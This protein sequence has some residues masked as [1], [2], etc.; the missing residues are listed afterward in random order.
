MVRKRYTVKIKLIVYQLKCYS[1]T[2]IISLALLV[3][4]L[5]LV[6]RAISL[7]LFLLLLLCLP[8]LRNMASLYPP[9]N[10]KS[11][12]TSHNTTQLDSK[13]SVIQNS[14]VHGKNLFLNGCCF[15]TTKLRV[16]FYAVPAPLNSGLQFFTVSLEGEFTSIFTMSS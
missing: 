2:S 3:L 8:S 12:G 11:R 10:R 6:F 16:T 15:R 1:P 13:T 9:R 4:R 5:K 14:A 7:L